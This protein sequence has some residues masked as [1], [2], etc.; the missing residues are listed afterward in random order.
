M[1]VLVVH[2]RAP[3]KEWDEGE[4]EEA[5]SRRRRQAPELLARDTQ[6]AKIRS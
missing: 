6:A 3:V 4:L 2:V 5:R 1:T